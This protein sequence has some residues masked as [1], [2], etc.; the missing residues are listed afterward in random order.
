MVKILQNKPLISAMM[1]GVLVLAFGLGF[2]QSHKQTFNPEDLNATVFNQP[3]IIEDFKLVNDQNKPYL[4]HNLLGHWTMMFFGFTHCPYVCPTTMSELNKTDELLSK[5]FRIKKP[6][7]VMVSIDPER[8]TPAEMNKYVHSFNKAFEGVTGDIKE[9]NHFAK[10]MD[11]LY[12]RTEDKK[13]DK[14]YNI[15][16]SAS[17]MLINPQGQLQAFFSMPYEAKD[18]VHSYIKITKHYSG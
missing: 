18:L 16:H 7:V 11:V 6:H 9:I 12:M 8:D 4:N 3:R 2:W 14:N 15:D 5:Q 1:L 13:S 17:I 10:N